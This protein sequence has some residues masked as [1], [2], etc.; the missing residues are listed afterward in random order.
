MS[1]ATRILP[2]SALLLLLVLVPLAASAQPR[3]P[4]RVLSA[5]PTGEVASIEEANEIRVV[6]SEP[7]AALGQ[8]PVRLRPAFFR[9]TP[10][11]AGT[12]RWSG[13]TVLIFTPAKRLPLATRYDVTIAATAAA[14]SGRSLAAPYRFSFTTPTARLLRT[15]WYRPGG[16]FDAAP[17]FVLRFN[18]PVR[19]PDVL[20]HVRAAFQSHPF[21]PPVIAAPAQARLR[22][23]DAGA[24]DAFAARVQRARDAANATLPVPLEIAPD[25]DKK[26]FKPSTDLVVLRAAA[27]VPPESWV[28][29][30]VDGR[31]P[32]TA[33]LAV[34]GRPQ[35]YTVKVEPAF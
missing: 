1:R 11:V 27:P 15:E 3:A 26:R 16:R 35:S 4:L 22:T 30:D 19:P 17:V 31:V 2:A 14:L 28:R 24:L 34:S 20:P 12:F 8:V 13:A 21:T 9:I 10:A 29:L 5:G 32:S 6:F 25:W 23:I 18:Q 33:G 7:M